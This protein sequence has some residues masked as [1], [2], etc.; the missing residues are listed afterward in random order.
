MPGMVGK[1]VFSFLAGV[2]V[3]DGLDKI[4][5]GIDEN[6]EYNLDRALKAINEGYKQLFYDKSIGSIGKKTH[7]EF[8]LILANGNR[9][10]EVYEIIGHEDDYDVT[11]NPIFINGTTTLLKEA[12]T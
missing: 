2:T 11:N 3:S 4:I 10:R 8:D 7:V 6:E 1:F 5:W 9:T 12:I